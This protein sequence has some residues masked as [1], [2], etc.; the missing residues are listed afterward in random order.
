MKHHKLNSC[1][2]N[3]DSYN[4]NKM[5]SRNSLAWDTLN[6]LQEINHLIMIRGT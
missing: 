6:W 4:K 2:N 3:L 5:N 1:K